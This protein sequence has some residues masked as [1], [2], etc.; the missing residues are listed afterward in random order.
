MTMTISRVVASRRHGRKQFD[1][2]SASPPIPF[3]SFPTFKC[4]RC[5]M[6]R[7]LFDQVQDIINRPSN[8][9]QSLS[10]MLIRE[11]RSKEVIVEDKFLSF[12]LYLTPFSAAEFLSDRDKPEFIY[13]NM[14][15]FVREQGQ[16]LAMNQTVSLNTLKLQFYHFR[17]RLDL[18][19]ISRR[20]SSEIRKQSCGALKCVLRIN[21]RTI[22]SR[23]LLLNLITTLTV[24]D[25]GF[26][27]AEEKFS[28]ETEAAVKSVLS[29]NDLQVF[30]KLKRRDKLEVL[31]DLKTIVCGVRLFS[32]DA[33]HEKG[34]RIIDCN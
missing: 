21:P 24:I 9:V 32:N 19:D 4:K 6:S 11:C 14:K 20:I 13:P 23:E 27:D 28:K 31:A 8:V 33:G 17:A 1:C 16:A 12:F 7:E 34:V 3:S 29:A 15:R 30:G 5:A 18:E 2:C 10:N 25:N 26:G 22:E